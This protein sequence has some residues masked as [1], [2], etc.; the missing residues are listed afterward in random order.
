[1]TC[2]DMWH[3]NRRFTLRYLRDQGMGKSSLETAISLEAQYLVEDFARF[4]DRPVELP[5][6]ISI[7]VLNVIWKMVAGM[8]IIL[9]TVSCR[10]L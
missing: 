3:T 9:C 8:L 7:A 2:G 6:S 10:S 1:M 5:M 4:T